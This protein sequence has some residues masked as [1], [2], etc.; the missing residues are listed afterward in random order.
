[1]VTTSKALPRAISKWIEIRLLGKP[2]LYRD[3]TG[4]IHWI[5]EYKGKYYMDKKMRKLVTKPIRKAEGILKKA[6][7]A[8]V[9][10]ANFDEKVRDPEIAKYKKLKMKGCK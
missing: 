7:K 10:L 3:I 1:M 4:E 6:E 9:K 5:Y 8:N 2:F